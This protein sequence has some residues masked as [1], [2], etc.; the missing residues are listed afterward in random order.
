MSAT[1]VFVS[2]GPQPVLNQRTPIGA[3][4][5]EPEGA[6]WR[7]EI[8]DTVVDGYRVRRWMIKPTEALPDIASM[9]SDAIMSELWAHPIESIETVLDDFGG[10]DVSPGEARRLLGQVRGLGF[11]A[12]AARPIVESPIRYVEVEDRMWACYQEGGMFV[13]EQSV[14]VADHEVQ[15]FLDM[16]DGLPLAEDSGVEN[17]WF[18]GGRGRRRAW[19]TEELPDGERGFLDSPRK[20]A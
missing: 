19:A 9:D 7:Q 13:L 18:V 16:A 20:A 2:P 17:R 8:S 1:Q 15:G 3:N 6:D 4:V 5:A 14:M 12:T 11:E 10:E